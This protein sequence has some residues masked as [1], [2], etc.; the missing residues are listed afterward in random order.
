VFCNNES[1]DRAALDIRL[2]GLWI[3]VAGTVRDAN[4]A[5]T[6]GKINSLSP[7]SLSIMS[8]DKVG[9][10]FDRSHPLWRTTRSG[11][12]GE[13]LNGVSEEFRRPRETFRAACVLPPFR[14]QPRLG[15][16]LQISSH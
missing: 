16:R 15:H 13:V 12:V 1:N 3:S 8:H 4:G 14:L 10:R 6:T 2:D 7:H 9:G 5:E 11:G